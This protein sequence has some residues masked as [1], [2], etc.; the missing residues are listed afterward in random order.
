M[1]ITGFHING[2]GM[3]HNLT[4]NGLSPQLTVFLGH[5]ESGKSTLLGFI[6]A[7]LFG[8]PDG[9]SNENLYPPLFGGRHGGNIT[10]QNDD[11]KSYVVERFPGAGG[12][13]VEVLKPDQTHG[14]KETLTSLLGTDNRM[15]FKNIYAFSLSE[16]QQF[17]T[18]NT[19][20]VRQTLYSAGAGINPKGLAMLKATLE[21]KDADLFKSGGNKPKINR[22]I[23]RLV[24]MQ[25]E[26]KALQGSVDEYDRLRSQISQLSNDI[27]AVEK[28]RVTVSLQLKKIENGIDIW[29]EWIGLVAAKEKLTKL[30]PVESF[31]VQ[32][33]T[34]LEGLLSRFD[35]LQSERFQKEEE[36]KRQESELPTQAKDS[37]ILKY[38]S[39]IRQ[40]QRDQ[41]HF[42]AIIQDLVS[43]KQEITKGEQKLEQD[44]SRLGLS[45]TQTRVMEFDL[46]IAAREEA[47]RFRMELER[48]RFEKERK[49]DLL[50]A[51]YSRKRELAERI[52]GLNEPSIKDNGYL[53]D[54]KRACQELRRL[55][56]QDRFV[57]EEDRYLN[58]RLKD[59]QEEKN[60]LGETQFKD[61]ARWPFRLVQGLWGFGILFLIGFGL[62]TGMERALIA[63]I[64]LAFF[65][66]VLWFMRASMIKGDMKRTEIAKRRFLALTSKIEDL[67]V[68]RGEIK[69]KIDHISGQMAPLC[70]FLS[71][72]HPLSPPLLD[73]MEQEFTDQMAQLARWQDALHNTEQA[74]KRYCDAQTEHQ[75]AEA[76]ANSA[77]DSWQTWLKDQYLDLALSPEGVIETFSLIE[78]C[79]DQIGNLAQLKSKMAS[80]YAAKERYLNLAGELF[81]VYDKKPTTEN[82]TQRAIQD[83]IQVFVESEKAHQKREFLSTEIQ[84]SRESID[85]LDAQIQKLQKEIRD[86]MG[87]GGADNEPTFRERA[88]IFEERT[89][90][91][92]DIQRYEDNSRRLS[93]KWG[94]LESMMEELSGQNIE[95]LEAKKITLEKD[96][97]DIDS[98]L[99]Q[100]KRDQ[101]R[102]DEQTRQIIDDERTSILRTEEEGLKEELSVLAEE[103]I[104][105][106]MAQMLIQTAREHYEKERQPKVISEAGRFFKKFTIGR[107]PSLVAPFGEDRIEVMSSDNSRKEID[108]LSRGT[109]EQL[110]LAL[111]FGFIQEFFKRSGS[112]PII[113]D[114]IL[115]NFDIDRTKATIEGI[116]EL[117]RKHQVLYFTCHPATV[118][119]FKEA[120]PHSL[121]LEIS[122][123]NLEEW[124]PHGT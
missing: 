101:T 98:T 75:H 92:K 61:R 78:S 15:L 56:S 58:E 21:K 104:T 53:R 72:S 94:G 50:E 67:E 43:V 117:S 99:E 52:S 60:V 80:L 107:Y 11:G 63:A 31:P 116:L 37:D 18:L 54:S 81:M 73:K 20:S 100:L 114:E 44:L 106:K 79:K 27:D 121:A 33:L 19:E 47:R 22:I 7:I 90:L 40:L 123:G 115:V 12:G 59:I 102:L 2:F 84:A 6:R 85:R 36:L 34:R 68:R 76:E 122:E 86:L 87:A 29:P 88:Q 65:G 24:A 42:E 108:Q 51:A 112:L 124:N 28:K 30:E 91:K 38:A 41:G 45:W 83:L 26:K 16:L 35:A 17:E 69:G 82:E 93:S 103:W 13:K 118:A 3:F 49:R 57:K 39:S 96:L 77:Q 97:N 71:L 1:R 32:G 46:S 8:F 10:L 62:K 74:E 120:D 25:K 70:S 119:L 113:M 109:A 89:V 64:V 66:V 110:Y 111:R 23:A 4:V 95:D 9:R 55:E 105:I 14:G 48:V 5:N